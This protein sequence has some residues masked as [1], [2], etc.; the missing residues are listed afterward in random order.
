[1]GTFWN[2]VR[3][4]YLG[5][6]ATAFLIIMLPVLIIANQRPQTITGIAEGATLLT[7][8]PI[9]SEKS[10]IIKNSQEIFYLDIMLDPGKNPISVVKL[11]I[12]YDPNK[13]RLTSK[14]PIMIND[15][16]LPVVLA[17]PII[18]NGRL[19][20]TLSIGSDKTKVLS[21]QTKVATINFITLTSTESTQVSFGSETQALTLS[22]TNEDTDNALSTTAPAYISIR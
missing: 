2:V 6:A 13:I 9:S 16:V 20:V 11:D 21:T 1:M 10:P 17:G 18:S 3:H 8:S 7:F 15:S 5:A 14:N 22:S 4:K 12:T 19:Q